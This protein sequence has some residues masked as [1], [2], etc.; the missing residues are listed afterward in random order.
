MDNVASRHNVNIDLHKQ[1]IPINLRMSRN[2]N[3][4]L[5]E[6]QGTHMNAQV[7]KG[8]V[9]SMRQKS[10]PIDNQFKQQ[11]DD[12]SESFLKQIS[13]NSKDID[14]GDNDRTS[15]KFESIPLR[16][17][18]DL[19]SASLLPAIMIDALGTVPNAEEADKVGM[20]IMFPSIMH[21]KFDDEKG[22]WQRPRS[23]S[24][25][26]GAIEDFYPMSMDS[27]D[28]CNESGHSSKGFL[29]FSL[30]S[31]FIKFATTGLTSPNESEMLISTKTLESSPEE[32]E[33]DES[34][35]DGKRQQGVSKDCGKL[36]SAGAFVQINKSF[37]GFAKRVLPS[38]AQSTAGLTLLHSAAVS[39][40]LLVPNGNNDGK[41]THSRTNTALSAYE[42]NPSHSTSSKLYSLDDFEVIRKVGKGGFARVFLV[43]QKKSNRKYFALKCI[44]K[45]D[46]IRLRQERQIMNEKNIL[47]KFKHIFI[48]DLFHTFQTQN[49]LFMTLEFVPGGD[50]YS[51]MKKTKVYY[52][53]T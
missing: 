29:G 35:N 51:L 27:S 2:D 24:L 39:Q 47:K 15:Q 42:I 6:E 45:A 25:E 18:R 40:G 9:L 50:L 11:L 44:K 4:V 16:A 14:K 37:S 12:L 22:N 19:D 23:K 34:H 7:E 1:D 10:D 13:H 52:S 46:I 31:K 43:Q 53:S 17:E 41:K 3:K 32:N 5:R 8:Y 38:A 20:E 49:F 36:L 26:P 21:P 48:V 30:N 28:V 33:E